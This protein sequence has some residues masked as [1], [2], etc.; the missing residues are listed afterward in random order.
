M[1]VVQNST[2]QCG[3]MKK[4][5]FFS[6][7]HFSLCGKDPQIGRVCEK[8]LQKRALKREGLKEG[9]WRGGGKNL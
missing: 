4:D 2:L 3:A 7:S 1:P 9:A 8:S 6:F 5:A